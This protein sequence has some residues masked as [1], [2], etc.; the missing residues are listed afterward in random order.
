MSSLH[1]G[2]TGKLYEQIQK[3]ILDGDSC[4]F[5]E[6]LAFAMGGFMN[7]FQVGNPLLQCCPTS[8]YIS[9]FVYPTK[10]SLSGYA[11]LL[12]VVLV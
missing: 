10:G 5:S 11:C 1:H 4:D 9:S 6:N 12:I 3:P 8:T 2:M 7:S